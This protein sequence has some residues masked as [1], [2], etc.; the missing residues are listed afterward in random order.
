M[1]E[2]LILFGAGRNG[3]KAL[4]KYGKDKVAYFCDNDETKQ[5]MF[6]E[7]IEVISFAK[8]KLLHDEGY[9]IM[10]TPANSA[11]LVGQLE[12]EG[13]YDYLIFFDDETNLFMGNAEKNEI[14]YDKQ[15]K[16]LQKIVMESSEENLLNSVVNFKKLSAEALRL[17]KDEGLSLFHMGFNNEGYYY[18]NVQSLME[19]AGLRQEDI[20]YFP[21]V[22]HQA[23]FP[24]YSIA[25]DYRTGVVFQGEYFKEKVHRRFPYIPVFSVGPYIHYAKGIYNKE[26]VIKEKKRL[27]KMLLVF[28][29][30]TIENTQREYSREK[31]VDSV[32]EHYSKKFDTIWM[33]VYWADI[34]D[35]VCDYAESKG[36][37]IV[38]A[39]FRFDTQ[40]DNRLKT[41]IELADAVV[42]GDIGTFIGYSFYME[43]PIYRLDISDRTTNC[44]KEF[45]GGIQQ[46]LQF[47]E[48]YNIFVDKFYDVFGSKEGNTD[49]Q[50]EWLEGM[51][52]FNLIRTPYYIKTMFE[53]CKDISLKC[54]GKLEDYSE[55][56]IS[57][58]KHYD[59]NNEFYKMT[60]LKN[61]LGNCIN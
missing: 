47:S 15:N 50:K 8:M 13:I 34:N 32:F 18:G 5:G 56:V 53:I 20:K 10:I 46:K 9:V 49:K 21:I 27:G 36:I 2:K 22:S 3:K 12:M 1:Q 51:N 61:A 4:A 33:C 57:T 52:G 48:E 37:H 42:C 16:K 29:P 7:E 41:I 17:N 31:F 55:A 60:I 45:Q 28:M 40:F 35:A 11:F 58:Y 14:A 38:S 25:F 43:K 26:Q 24:L 30:H 23:C 44:N 19:Y 59:K 6:I 39:G 54:N